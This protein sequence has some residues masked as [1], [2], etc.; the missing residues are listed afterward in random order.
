MLLRSDSIMRLSRLVF[1]H[2]VVNGGWVNYPQT[3]L[4]AAISKPLGISGRAFATFPEYDVATRCRFQNIFVTFQKSNMAAGKPEMLCNQRK[5][6]IS[7][8]VI[9]LQMK[10]RRLPPHCRPRPT[11]VWDCRHG[12]TSADIRNSKWRPPNRK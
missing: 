10:L 5:Y 12:L 4:F 1:N 3:T 11:Q 9:Q 8:F 2:Y 7:L 6:K